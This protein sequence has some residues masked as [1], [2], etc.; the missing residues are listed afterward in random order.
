MLKD[1]IKQ[2]EILYSVLKFLHNMK[3]H[4]FRSQ[5]LSIGIDPCVL[6]IK[7]YGELNKGKIIYYIYSNSNLRG[8]FS[9]YLLVLDG[10]YFADEFGLV[11]VVEFGRDTLYHEK[12]AVNGSENGFEYYFM[13]VSDIP[14]GDVKK[15]RNVVKME[16]LHRKLGNEKFSM[17]IGHTLNN[18]IN[19]S[20]NEYLV[21]RA[22]LARKYIKLKPPVASY[23]TDGIKELGGDFRN[24]LG[25]HVRG[26]DFGKGYRGH[27]VMI[28]DE[29]YLELAK[30]ELGGGHFD[31]VFLATDQETTI[32][33]FR[34]V[35]GHKLLVYQDAFH[36]TNGE[37]VHFSK[38]SREHH[39]Y[40]LGL[41][42]LRDVYTL[43]ACDGLIAGLSN[44]SIAARIIKLSK[45]EE[46]LLTDILDKGT[47][48]HGRLMKS[49]T[50][51]QNREETL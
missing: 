26:T 31:R 47:N 1:K 28:N 20:E 16:S 33:K 23:I 51:K 9:L 25:V 10:L 21:S 15:S 4:T 18:K 42:V 13:P 45:N 43:A 14:Y 27:A 46:F 7:R 35:F 17:T 32:E 2:N 12:A 3:N 49:R 6:C 40:R 8:F 29:D 36:S 19:E 11:P 24:I 44:V 50:G 41:E 30:K 5:L 22:E 48:E 34:K 38:V 37:A 39:Q